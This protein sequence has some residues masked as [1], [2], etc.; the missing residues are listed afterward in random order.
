[1][2]QHFAGIADAGNFH[3]YPVMFL[4]IMCMRIKLL[5][6]CLTDIPRAEAKSMQRFGK[7]YK[8]TVVNG[9]E[10]L[11]EVFCRNNNRYIIF[12]RPL[13]Y[14]PHIDT[15]SAKGMKQL[16]RYARSL[17]HILAHDG[18]DSQ[19]LLNYYL[20]QLVGNQL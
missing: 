4:Q 5:K 14:R 11:G 6:Q 3:L 12:R 9:I 15:V 10:R 1:V 13:C 2:E 16:A 8:K 18:D 17:L 20:L 7:L 19:V